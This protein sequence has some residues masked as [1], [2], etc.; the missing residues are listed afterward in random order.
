MFKRQH[1]INF[2]EVDRMLTAGRSLVYIARLIKCS[3]D[4]LRLAIIKRAAIKNK[5]N[6][7]T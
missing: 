1:S 4:S 3:P 6:A 2:K 7:S 5:E